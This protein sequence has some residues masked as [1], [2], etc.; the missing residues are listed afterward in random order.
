MNSRDLS[1]RS[2][3]RANSPLLFARA[4]RPRF[5]NE[6]KQFIRFPTVSA[7]PQYAAD[8]Q[9]CARW[10]AQHLQRIGLKHVR[11]LSTPRH[12]IVYADWL[13]RPDRPTVLIYGHY[14]VQ[15]A[16]PLREW[17]TP[18]FNPVVRGEDV[19]GRGASDDKGQMLTHIKAVESFL[20]TQRRLPVNIKCLFEGEEE[21]G[22][23]NLKPFIARHRKALAADAA[24]MSDT[25]MLSP[26]Q[27][28]L[29]Y[30]LRGGLS[31]ELEVAGQ[32]ADLHSGNFGGAV[33]N[34]LQALCEIIA[35]LYDQNG[36]ITIPGFYDRVRCR[37]E[38]E[39]EFMADNGPSDVQLLRDAGMHK[40]WGERGWSLYERV[41]I[42]PSLSVTG[43]TGGYQGAGVKAV[44]PA[45][46]TAKLNFRLVPDQQP[47]EIEQLFRQHL[48][49]T[50]PPTVCA[51]IRQYLSAHP[52]LI[53][54]HHPAMQAA[55]MAYRQSFGRAPVWLRSGGTIPVVNS[56]QELLGIP[57][58][59]MG[60]ALPDDRLHGPNEK[61]HLPNFYRG[62]E[63]ALYFLE[64]ISRKLTRP[65]SIVTLPSDGRLQEG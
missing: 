40:G 21:I 1:P 43:I 55:S 15:P 31:L 61:F 52:A 33:H 5:L 47:E 58:V 50:V 32:K 65:R 44:I 27:P 25:R 10:L 9:R 51:T 62:I 3:L 12:P 17:R 54:R 49:H 41:T 22:S 30:S 23:P 8:I 6:L 14:D 39:R 18:P 60:F 38:A 35:A 57:V 48:A 46:A 63:T 45:R 7:Q 13:H 36:R 4:H 2:A 11:V 19:F 26:E 56:L 24:V 20:Q 16:E 59:L 37:S 28:A 34:P 53:D 29:T 42:R 64:N